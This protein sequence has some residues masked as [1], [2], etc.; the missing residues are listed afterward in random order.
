MTAMIA[1]LTDQH[2]MENMLVFL[3]EVRFCGQF[4]PTREL[5]RGKRYE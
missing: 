5:D 1:I 2:D 3:K 4:N